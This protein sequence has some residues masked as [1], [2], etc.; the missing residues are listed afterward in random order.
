M[1]AV[2]E[3]RISLLLDEMQQLKIELWQEEGK[4][5]FRD[6]HGNLT[7]AVRE[8]LKTEKE[9]ILAYFEAVEQAEKLP[10]TPLQYA[11]LLGEREGYELGGCT[12]HYYLEY[13]AEKV[14]KE[15]LED[16]L[17]RCI[18]ENDALRMKIMPS[19]YQYVQSQV[20]RIEIAQ[21][22]GE[23]E[24]KRIRR[25]RTS[26]G[27]QPGQWPMFHFM[28][29]HLEDKDILHIDFDC[30]ILDAGSARIM[31]QKVLRDYNGEEVNYPESGFEDYLKIN[32]AK[33]MDEKAHEYWMER[34]K[35]MPKAPNLPYTKP[36]SQ[37]KNIRFQRLEHYFTEEETTGLYAFAKKNH[38]SLAA[39]ICTCFA[40]T[41]YEQGGD[42]PLTL[43]LTLF[44][45]ELV[46][47]EAKDILGEFTN[48]GFVSMEEEKESF[49]KQ[50]QDVQL[51]FWKLLQYRSYDGTKVLKE[52]GKGRSAEA[53]MPVVFTCVLGEEGENEEID[54]FKEIYSLSRTPQVSLDH[55]V[56]E[57]KGK[58]KI[59]WDYIEELF[60]ERELRE[61]FD[62]YV[63][64]IRQVTM[65]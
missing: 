45:R 41:L 52:L 58:L 50:V 26:F 10:L 15:R 42:S 55:H 51:Q 60:E 1:Q 9:N 6:Y 11:Y 12:A 44:S 33:P 61:I 49:L 5:K 27:Y 20:R 16:A 35:T 31:I 65:Q 25:E 8:R 36:F 47:E 64:Q 7:P 40:K 17:N 34:C 2:E 13:E 18:S 59:S 21:S 63:N 30:M 22:R 28:L 19:G 53:I 54:G 4:L 3:R 46:H 62:T 39:L 56:R 14:D 48:I 43:N 24:W 23:E 37:V 32:A 38:V 57:N 29:T